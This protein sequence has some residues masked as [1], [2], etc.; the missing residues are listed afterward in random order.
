MNGELKRAHLR[1]GGKLG[2]QCLFVEGQLVVGVK[3][4][5]VKRC[6]VEGRHGDLASSRVREEDVP[7]WG[8]VAG[9]V[10]YRW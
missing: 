7:A 4:W 9:E 8:V 2:T 6:E 5:L 3:D 10:G 1:R